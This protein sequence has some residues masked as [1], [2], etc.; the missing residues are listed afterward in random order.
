V[1]AGTTTGGGF[2]RTKEDQ[3]KGYVDLETKFADP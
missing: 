1:R 2:Y 3:N